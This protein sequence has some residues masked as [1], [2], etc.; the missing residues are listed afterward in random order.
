M[1]SS[2]SST[3]V[4]EESSSSSSPAR[5]GKDLPE[6]WV[7]VYRAK[8]MYN[9]TKMFSY[10]ASVVDAT[11]GAFSVTLPPEE[12]K[13]PGIYLAEL[14]IYD[15]S[16]RLR[17]SD[18]RYLKVNVTLECSHY[19]PIM[20]S[21][22]RMALWDYCPEVNTLIDDFEF[23]EEQIIYMIRRPIDLWNEL[24]P[25]VYNANPN[26]FKWR[27]HWL[28]CTVGYLLVAASR[29]QKR[30]TLNYT[31]SGLSLQSNSNWQAY[32]Q[33]GETLIAEFKNWAQ[34]KKIE[35]NVSGGYGTFGS[36]Y[37]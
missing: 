23:P 15:D 22:V 37:S 5:P 11:Y 10:I 33:E 1:S 3:S 18:M 28:R 8:Q 35:I 31:A 19:G 34:N 14:A 27:E 17:F 6:G 25:N 32:Y 21:D 2:S 4:G 24:L 26:N 13:C 12:I 9:S 7:A 29:L 36:S 30:N 20:P 16:N